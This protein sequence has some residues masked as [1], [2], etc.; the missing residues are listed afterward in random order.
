MAEFRIKGKLDGCPIW[1]IT[2]EE[3]GYKLWHWG[4]ATEFDNL[5]LPLELLNK[6]V[7]ANICKSTLIEA[8]K[9]FGEYDDVEDWSKEELIEYLLKF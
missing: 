7:G 3:S 6:S 5:H 2:K 9:F 4:I 1:E 8:V